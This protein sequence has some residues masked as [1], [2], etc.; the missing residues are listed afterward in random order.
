MVASISGSDKTESLPG[1]LPP[2]LASRRV[3]CNLERA[4][5]ES[6]LIVALVLGFN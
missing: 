6:T 2:Q 1:L 4:G 3:L 5:Q